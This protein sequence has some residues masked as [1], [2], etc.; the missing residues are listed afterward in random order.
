MAD[1]VGEEIPDGLGVGVV[2]L[3]PFDEVDGQVGQL[4]ELSLRATHDMPQVD[5]ESTVGVASGPHQVDGLRQG[6]HRREGQE[7]QRHHGAHLGKGDACA[8][9]APG[10]R[11]E[12]VGRVDHPPGGHGMDGADEGRAELDVACAQGL[13]C[14]AQFVTHPFRLDAAWTLRHP[15]VLEQFEF[16]RR[17]AV[18]VEKLLEFGEVVADQIAAKVG[19]EDAEA[20]ES[21]SRCGRDPIGQRQRALHGT[22]G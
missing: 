14:R 5:Q 17:H 18:V 11:L 16:H 20:R 6:A 3:D 1:R 22:E 7:L 13:G 8:V 12:V 19:Q 21:S 9:E 4:L 10:I 15:P 2:E